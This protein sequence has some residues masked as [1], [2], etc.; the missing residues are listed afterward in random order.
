MK[1]FET[2]R[3]AVRRIKEPDRQAMLEFHNDPET[4]K[5]VSFFQPQSWTAADLNKKLKANRSLYR[6]GFGIYCVES[7]ADRRVIGEASVFN[8]FSDVRT[9]EIGYIIRKDCWNLGYGTEIVKGLVGYC[10]DV[11]KVR[12]IIA[13][14]YSE[15]IFSVRLCEK[16]GMQLAD[17]T[18]LK[19]GLHRLTYELYCA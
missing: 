4:M 16:T 6:I 3:L 9:P 2:D 18:A 13:R 14:V 1:I 17:N 19:N 5:F 12:K 15:N 8:S 10:S 11:L 7:K